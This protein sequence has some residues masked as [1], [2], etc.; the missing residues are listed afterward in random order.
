[1]QDHGDSG[2]GESKRIP[3]AYWAALAQELLHPLQI[4]IIEAMWESDEPL[5]A[6]DLAGTLKGIHSSTIYHHLKGRLRRI[7]AVAYAKRPT[8]RNVIDIPFRIVRS[9]DDES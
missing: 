8:A 2:N 4:S 9:P 1:M 3:D 6:K 7:N 5:T